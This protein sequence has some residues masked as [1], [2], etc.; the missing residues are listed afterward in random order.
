MARTD[1]M[2][3]PS[4]LQNMEEIRDPKVETLFR[5]LGASYEFIPDLAV[6]KVDVSRGLQ[7]QPRLGA[8][9]DKET[10]EKYTEDVYNGAK[11]PPITVHKLPGGNSRNKHTHAPLDG[12]HRIAA[13]LAAGEPT[14]PAYVVAAPPATLALIASVIN[15]L[16]GL[17]TNEASRLHHAEFALNSGAAPDQVA[18]LYGLR[19]PAVKRLQL[20]RKTTQRASDARIPTDE[21]VKLPADIR[22]ILGCVNTDEGMRELFKF[23]TRTYLPAKQMRELVSQVN[24]TKSSTA[25]VTLIQNLYPLFSD[26]MTELTL[27][28]PPTHGRKIQRSPA[29]RTKLVFA[30]IAAAQTTYPSLDWLGAVD[31]GTRAAFRGQ[32]EQARKWIDDFLAALDTAAPQKTK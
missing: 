8:A 18:R 20:L 25:Q 23:Y 28:G 14:I 12:N 3:M 2:Q 29:H 19:A 32:A 30:Q 1:Q 15:T 10:L 22:H 5:E 24:E 17:Q 9:L 21:W 13:Y 4:V 16:N 31:P 11:F 27:Q 7:N 26:R 6:A